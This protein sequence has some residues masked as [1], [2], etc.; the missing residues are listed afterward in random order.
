MQKQ[1]KENKH[2]HTTAS[3]IQYKEL[4]Q[5]AHITQPDIITK[6]ETH[7]IQDSKHSKLPIHQHQH[8]QCRTQMFRIHTNKPKSNLYIPLQDVA[9]PQ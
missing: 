4:K 5:L 9:S 8:T 7:N 3:E 6:P 2:T 1:N